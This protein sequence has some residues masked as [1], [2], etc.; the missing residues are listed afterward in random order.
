MTSSQA[1]FLDVGNS[2]GA[3]TGVSSSGSMA[4]GFFIKNDVNPNLLLR[5]DGVCGTV[6]DWIDCSGPSDLLER[7]N[8][9]YL[10]PGYPG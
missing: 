3:D 9:S 1:E 2:I 5:F 7:A 6:V 4:G 10:L 8:S